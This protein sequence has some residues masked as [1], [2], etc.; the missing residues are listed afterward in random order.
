MAQ[1]FFFRYF[2]YSRCVE[3][4][5]QHIVTLSAIFPCTMEYPSKMSSY[6]KGKH[7]F[8]AFIS[9]QGYVGCPFKSMIHVY[10]EMFTAVDWVLNELALFLFWRMC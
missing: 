4:K 5:D 7:I 8:N 10:D 6:N 9:S 2:C 1:G 3:T